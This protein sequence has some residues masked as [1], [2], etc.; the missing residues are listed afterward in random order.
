MGGLDRSLAFTALLEFE[1]FRRA[2]M[3]AGDKYIAALL[4]D[5]RASAE[6]NIWKFAQV[7]G[8]EVAG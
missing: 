7:W 2:D 6:T 3:R 5:F 8:R 4:E 1:W